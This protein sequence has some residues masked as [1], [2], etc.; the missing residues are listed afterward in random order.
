MKFCIRYNPSDLPK[1]GAIILKYVS[2]H[3]RRAIMMYEGIV[4]T[5][6]SNISENLTILEKAKEPGNLYFASGYA[7]IDAIM[8]WPNVPTAVISTVLKTYRENGI[9]E[10]AI[11]RNKSA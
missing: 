6:V 2:T 9:H 4:R 11:K 3:P 10:F 8:I 5:A 1:A 7:A